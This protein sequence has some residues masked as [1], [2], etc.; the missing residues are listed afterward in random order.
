MG[1]RWDREK[2]R[3]G[4][5]DKDMGNGKVGKMTEE[6]REI[7]NVNNIQNSMLS[8]VLTHS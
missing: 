1:K 3:G 8:S 5:W 2:A 6:R 4:K 7:I